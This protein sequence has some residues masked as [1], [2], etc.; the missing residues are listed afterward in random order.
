MTEQDARIEQLGKEVELLKKRVNYFYE[1]IRPYIE[2]KKD[3]LVC[4]YKGE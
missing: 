3:C 4:E 1:E 2:K